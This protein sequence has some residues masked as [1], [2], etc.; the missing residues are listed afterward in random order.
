MRETTRPVPPLCVSLQAGLYCCRTA[1]SHRL[2]SAPTV[3]SP[4]VSINWYALQQY[5]FRSELKGKAGCLYPQIV[6][7]YEGAIRN[8]TER[9]PATTSQGETGGR[10]C[11]LIFQTWKLLIVWTT[12]WDR[13]KQE[14]IGGIPGLHKVF[15]PVEHAVRVR[16]DSRRH[17]SNRSSP[18]ARLRS[19]A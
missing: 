10:I 6:G 13:K 12:W 15:V 4:C 7:S 2:R 14:S 16:R 8:K 3:A 9:E 18:P 11:A 5:S 17:I 19:G 1:K